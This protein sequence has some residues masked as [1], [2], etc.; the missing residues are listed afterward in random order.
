MTEQ[1]MVEIL[2]KILDAI[3]DNDEDGAMLIALS[4]MAE[5]LEPYAK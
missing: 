5:I 4:A 2:T 1:R 3:V